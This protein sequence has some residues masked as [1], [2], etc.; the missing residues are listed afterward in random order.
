M[1]SV[2]EVPP[3]FQVVEFSLARL[4]NWGLFG[5]LSVQVYLYYEAFPIDRL[6]I[7]CLVYILFT[8]DV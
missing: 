8:I 2:S 1:D 7:K 6:I 5:T 4:L 3:G